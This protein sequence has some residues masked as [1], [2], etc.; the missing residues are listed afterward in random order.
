MERDREAVE[1]ELGEA[2]LHSQQ[3]EVISPWS[4]ADGQRLLS[5][6][7][8]SLEA[9]REQG[10]VRRLRDTLAE[11]IDR[12]EY[13]PEHRQAIVHSRLTGINVASPRGFEPRLPP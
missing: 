13:D 7:R 10:Q 11:L 2:E 8:D 4:A 1:G 3:A 5:T 6:L 9:D 12:I